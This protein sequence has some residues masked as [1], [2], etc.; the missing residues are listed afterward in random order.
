MP[1]D[2]L[3]FSTVRIKNNILEFEN[4]VLMIMDITL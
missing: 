4:E 1:S 3:L 2:I